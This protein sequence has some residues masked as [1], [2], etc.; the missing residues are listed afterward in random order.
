MYRE[1]GWGCHRSHQRYEKARRLLICPSRRAQTSLQIETSYSFVSCVEMEHTASLNFKCTGAVLES[2][3]HIWSSRRNKSC[4]C[5]YCN[6]F[7]METMSRNINACTNI[8]DYETLEPRM[9]Q[10]DQCWGSLCFQVGGPGFQ[11]P[12]A[13]TVFTST[14]PKAFSLPLTQWWVGDWG[15]FIFGWTVPL[16]LF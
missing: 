1:Q 14:T 6:R 12:L 15:I 5:I 10:H 16:I 8:Y 2:T 11:L 7:K 13:T 3:K 9:V 4:D